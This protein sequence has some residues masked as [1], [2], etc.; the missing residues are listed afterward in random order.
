MTHFC[1]NWTRG[2]IIWDA[3]CAH[4][5]RLLSP[6]DVA[7]FAYH[8]HPVMYR[9]QLCM[10]KGR[11]FCSSYDGSQGQPNILKAYVVRRNLLLTGS[12]N[13]LRGLHRS[14]SRLHSSRAANLY[15]LP[16]HAVGCSTWHIPKLRARMHTKEGQQNQILADGEDTEKNGPRSTSDEGVLSHNGQLYTIRLSFSA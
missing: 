13:H 1:S 15:H 8:F 10:P 9:G 12:C 4:N 2:E 11:L 5:L 16:N 3:N 6:N 14:C 7:I